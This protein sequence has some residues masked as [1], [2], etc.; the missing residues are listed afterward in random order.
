M[1]LQTLPIHFIDKQ[2]MRWILQYKRKSAGCYGEDI[3]DAAIKIFDYEQLYQ[4]V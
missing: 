2:D 1:A 3:H 4:S